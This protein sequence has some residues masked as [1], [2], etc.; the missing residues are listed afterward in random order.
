MLI[1]VLASLLA[2]PPAGDAW[3]VSLKPAIVVQAEAPVVALPELSESS[4][5]QAQAAPQL[6][7]AKAL[8]PKKR[9]KSSKVRPSLQ[10]LRKGR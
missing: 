10:T 8:I 6:A 3:F 2:A 1:F 4:T 9:V 5:Q 7:P